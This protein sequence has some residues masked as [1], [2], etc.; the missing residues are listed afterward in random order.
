MTINSALARVT[1][2]LNRFGF[3]RK[4]RLCLTSSSICSGDERTVLM[5]ITRRSW[6]VGAQESDVQQPN[7]SN[8]GSKIAVGSTLEF[9]CGSNFGTADA[10]QVQCPLD[11]VHLLKATTAGLLS[12]TDA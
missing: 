4:P 7:L 1:A 5:I 9:F 8:R 3:E 11:L 12:F 2:T 6:P 10:L